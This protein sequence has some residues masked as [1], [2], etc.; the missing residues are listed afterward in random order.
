MYSGYNCVIV[1]GHSK[2]IRRVI[3]YILMLACLYPISQADCF[4]NLNP[5]WTHTDSAHFRIRYPRGSP[6]QA[7]IVE[8]TDT[9][10]QYYADLSA[11][12]PIPEKGRIPYYYHNRQLFSGVNPV[13]GYTT[14]Y[15]IHAVYS[16]QV[17]DTSPHELRHFIQDRIN[18]NAPY[19]FNEGACGIGIRIEGVDFASRARVSC[20]ALRRVSLTRLVDRYHMHADRRIDF[21]TYA[22]AEYL[23][24]TYG[25]EMFGRFYAGATRQNWKGVFEEVYGAR[26]D[27]IEAAWKTRVCGDIP[28]R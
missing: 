5:L 3:L 14:D 15:S 26:F 27:T 21:W 9:L 4:I 12:F 24:E 25:Q 19:F 1:A 18:P 20:D 10:E 17:K 28:R 2:T 13:W 11:V 7:N 6:A 16:H 8:L 23:L 22:F